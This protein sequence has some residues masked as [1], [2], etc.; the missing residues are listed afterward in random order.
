MLPALLGAGA[1]LLI[2]G[3]TATTMLMAAFLSGSGLAC[4]LLLVLRRGNVMQGAV[5]AMDKAHQAAC[6]ADADAFLGGLAQLESSVISVWAKQ[7]ETG[8]MQSEQAMNA[9]TTRFIGIANQLDQAVNASNLSAESVDNAHGLVAVFAHSESQLQSVIASLRA[10]L[11]HSDTLLND[12]GQLVQF[13]DQLRDMATS[14]A[15]IAD[16]TILLALNA[17][18]EAARAGESGR[19]FAVVADE[20]RKLSS[21]SKETGR[22]I[23]DKVQV[24][25]QA[26]AHAFD[27]AEQNAAQD[28]SAAVQSE[29][30]IRQV[31]DAFRTVTG[32]L[33]E[34]AAILRGASAGIK[35]EVSESLV[36]LQFQD[37]VSQILCH[38]RDN[39]SAFPAYL[40][41]ADA[42]Y[43]EHG[44]LAA[45][46]WSGLLQA[47]EQS[48]ATT[49]ERMNHPGA[50]TATAASKEITFF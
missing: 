39:I 41:Q 20:V 49:E 35:T 7:I 9:L 10:A 37:R 23:S 12:V 25:S 18:I 44:R 15:H 38:V 24:I 46:N 42:H 28:T 21:M 34:S 14:V 2:G 16:Q 1:V 36:Q 45:I 48:Y 3:V 4:A 33:T 30:A 5:D 47:L 40:R 19:G 27:V 13:I 6:Q 8:R 11:S 22:G 31:L 26:I 29:A 32:G 50:Q 43:Q 17:A